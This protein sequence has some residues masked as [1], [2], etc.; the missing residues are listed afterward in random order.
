MLVIIGGGWAGLACAAALKHRTSQPICIFEAAPSLGGRARGLIWNDRSIDNGQHLT[1]G[2]YRQT[3]ALLQAAGAPAWVK[4]PLNWCGVGRHTAIEQQWPVPSLAWPGRALFAAIPGC[5]PKG[6][7]NTWRLSMAQT[8]FSLHRQS[9]ML[10]DALQSGASGLS[11]AQWLAQRRVPQGL[12]DHFWRP[13]TEGALNTELETARPSTMI[14]VLR[15]SLAGP[16][17]ACDVWVP[18]DNLSID[19]VEPIAAWL[20]REGVRIKSGHRVQSIVPIEGQRWQVALSANPAQPPVAADAVVIALP[21]HASE[22]LWS[23]SALTPTAASRRWGR[24]QHRAIT[25]IW[26]A[27]TKEQENMLSHLPPWFVL[28]PVAGLP[29]HGQVAV[30]RAGTLGVVM[31]AQ[32]P[33]QP[34][35]DREHIASQLAL[36]LGQQLNLSY[37]LDD[38]KW[39]TEKTATWACTVDA[40]SP[41]EDEQLGRTGMPGLFRCADDLV[42]HYPATIESAV[43][44]AEN[45]ATE[46]IRFLSAR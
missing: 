40:P 24:L 25:T 10:P 8:L 22:R 16:A 20:T 31:S 14:R 7:P 39:I 15:D 33:D 32:H 27:L 21:F 12:I 42:E 37:S 9:W 30:R 2:A 19:G 46:V 34:R 26:I 36:Q 17:G 18:R 38:T 11:V 29:H 4:A 13:F 43:R 45:T 28:N 1:I 6:W 3:F 44:S 41:T 5:G 35:Q 23:D